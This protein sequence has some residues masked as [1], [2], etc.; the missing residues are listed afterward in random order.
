MHTGLYIELNI[1][2]ILLLLIFYIKIEANVY[3]RRIHRLLSC[4][5][6]MYILFFSSDFLWKMIDSNIIT[7]SRE[8]NYIVNSFYFSISGFA[9]LFWVMYCIHTQ[10]HNTLKKRLIIGI[11]SIPTIVLLIMSVNSPF[12]GWIFY[13]DEANN[14]H[15]GPFYFLQIVI[16]LGYLIFAIIFSGISSAKKENLPYRRLYLTSMLVPVLVIASSIS[17]IYYPDYPMLPASLTIGFSLMYLAIIDSQVLIDRMTTLYNRNWF[18]QHHLNL[19][20]TEGQEKNRT[21]IIEEIILIDIDGLRLINDAH[22]KDTGDDALIRLSNILMDIQRASQIPGYYRAVRF[23]DDEFV[24]LCEFADD[25]KVETVM[26][27]I[28][29]R[30]RVLNASG[31]VPYELSV[32]MGHT[33]YLHQTTTLAE[34]MDFA[35]QDMYKV[36]VRK[37]RD[38]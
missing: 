38:M 33:K 36:K 8:I 25:N 13:L 16:T 12:T 15:R 10:S 6:I 11:I 28:D 21:N 1:L 3:L 17:Q 22:G 2:C 30:L 27:Y 20:N 19:L 9:A 5:A 18:Y 31:T 37:Q 4:S 26:N 35:D 24:V 14:Y 32:S 7:A 34:L 23:G 29:M